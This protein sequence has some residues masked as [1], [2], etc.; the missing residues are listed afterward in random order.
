MND[1]SHG[2]GNVFYREN[3]TRYAP[4]NVMMH[5]NNTTTYTALQKLGAPSYD[6]APKHP[7][8]TFT[9]DPAPQISVPDHGATWQYDPGSKQYLKSQDGRAE[10]AC[11]VDRVALEQS[12]HSRDEN[13]RHE[14]HQD[15]PVA[16]QT[17]DWE[18]GARRD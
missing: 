5:G 13:A 3:A 12:R 7:D 4:H 8:A 16:K 14:S 1:Y 18:R 17:R 2:W 11:P 15:P 9:G 10:S 6:I